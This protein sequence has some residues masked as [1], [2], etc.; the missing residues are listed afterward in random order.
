MRLGES[1]AAEKRYEEALLHYKNALQQNPDYTR[2]RLSLGR[3]YLAQGDLDAAAD[4]LERAEQSVSDVSQRA[5]LQRLL[6]ITY[7]YQRDD[8]ALQHVID[9]APVAGGF[10]ADLALYEIL[11]R[12]RN[13]DPTGAELAFGQIGPDASD[14][15][16]GA[17]LFLYTRAQLESIK[18]PAQALATLDE[19]LSPQWQSLGKEREEARIVQAYGYLLRGQLHSALR[20]P[21]AAM[22]DFEAFESRQPKAPIVKLLLAATALQLRDLDRAEGHLD[23]LLLNSPGQPLAAMLKAI[24][25]FEKKDCPKA[26]QYA[27]SSINNGLRAPAN[28]VI[29]GV[30][31]YHEGLFATAYRHVKKALGSYPDNSDLLR[32]KMVLDYKFGYLEEASEIYLSRNLDSMR[33]VL[34]GNAMAY[35][36][37][38]AGDEGQARRLLTRLQRESAASPVAAVQFQAIARQLESDDVLSAVADDAV[39]PTEDERL[40]QN[41]MLIQAGDLE[42]AYDSVEQW[43]ASVPE[44]VDA[45]N[46]LAY[47]SQKKGDVATARALFDQAL[48]TQPDNVPSFLFTA[49]QAM[50][51]GD[52]PEARAAF[53]AVL[54]INPRHLVA[55]QGILELSFEHVEPPDWVALLEA[56]DLQ[57]VSDDHWVAI[58]HAVFKWQQPRVLDDLLFSREPRSNWS[59]MLWMLWLKTRYA[60]DGVDDFLPNVGVYLDHNA[61]LSHVL[62]ALSI[63]QTHGKY[64]ETLT[65]IDKLA[66]ELRHSQA[67]Q[68]QRVIAFIET[69]AHDEARR[70]LE[71]LEGPDAVAAPTADGTERQTGNVATGSLWYAKGRLKEIEGD[72]A[73]ATSYFTA[74]HDVSP[75]FH[76]VTRLARVLIRAER[77]DEAVDLAYSYRAAHPSDY[78]ASLSLGLSLAAVR[79]KD[80]LGLL[81][82]NAV[83]GLVLRDARLSNNLALLHASQGDYLSAL[84]HSSN[85]LSL[86]ASDTRIR[87]L[88]AR[89]LIALGEFDEAEQ[90]L[91]ESPEQDAEITAM[92][93]TLH[94]RAI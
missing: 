60:V 4:T 25:A 72:L 12:L 82:A 64:Q 79:P 67:I 11:I 54:R 83:R 77:V 38:A 35:Q 2:A 44:N 50:A 21:R 61:A 94:T 59:P 65:L 46:L 16:H 39:S 91:A 49:Q 27:E 51:T 89:I 28:S 68:A 71:T 33:N 93:E 55:L 70:L 31:A 23:T 57:S 29:A 42:G 85:A 47:L 5:M 41:L 78:A 48:S 53:D 88:H 6:A 32:L 13:G 58:A 45:L 92:L 84:R 43:R 37:L 20:N 74:Y 8:L 17:A 10:V 34:L 14:N 18:D 90:V 36:L 40:L 22:E 26:R 81:D 86:D 3:V 69:G 30:C 75:S 66:D 56:V 19:L 15:A 7:Y 76:S 63:L 52:Y 62:Y 87:L 73:Q 9:S 24:I 80:A 1:T